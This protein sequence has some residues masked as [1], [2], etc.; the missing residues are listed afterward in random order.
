MEIDTSVQAESENFDTGVDIDKAM[1]KQPISNH[2]TLGLK[3][4]DDF[5]DIG[6]DGRFQEK[7]NHIFVDEEDVHFLP[8]ARS[9][10]YVKESFISRLSA[11]SVGPVK[12]FNIMKT[13]IDDYFRN[14][15]FS[16]ALLGSETVDYYRWL[17]SSFVNVFG[18]EPKVVVT[19]QDAAM[20]RAIKDFCSPR[21]T[22]VE[23]F[24]HFE[25]TMEFRRHA[26]RRNDHDKMETDVVITKCMSKTHH[27][28][29]D[30]E[31]FEI[32]DFKQPCTSSFKVQYSKQ[33]DGITICCTCKRFEQFGKLCR[34]ILYVLRY[35]DI[36][37]FPR[38]SV[39]RRWMRDVVSNSS[40]DCNI[41][42]DEI[43]RSS[44]I[45]KV[46]WGFNELCRYRD[47]IKSYM[48]K[49]DEIMVVA[50]PPSRKDRFADMGG[51]FEKSN[52]TIRVPIKIRT[53]GYGVQKR[54]KT[55][56]EIA[57]QKFSKIQKS[58]H[59]CSGKRHNNRTCKEKVSST[60]IGSNKTMMH[61]Y[62][63]LFVYCV[64]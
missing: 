52:S 53:K 45:D 51:N 36:T 46:G 1:Q 42:F 43:S 39:L 16:S 29:G 48:D 17:L 8:A 5:G 54:L 27:T 14:I 34:Q 60:V 13:M 33:E 40:I 56:R 64:L 9:I 38:R 31:F 2:V 32:R 49:A 11:I 18:I 63:L 30:V 28:L 6:F 41:R 58:C 3:E 55:N 23:F 22:L 35:V 62:Q 47:H 25:T 21:C 7:H 15:T 20:K 57:I 61:Y 26:H 4:H 10:D 12:A 24:T 37:E 44:E 59:V 19:D 50:P